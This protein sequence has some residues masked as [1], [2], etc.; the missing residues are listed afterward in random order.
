MWLKD[1]DQNTKYFHACA[2]Q[3]HKSNHLGCIIDINGRL[4]NTHET[5]SNAFVNYFSQLFRSM[6]VGNVSACL[7]A[8]DSKLT[9]EMNTALL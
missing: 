1:G 4:W 8:L 6:P 5:V 3:R 7:N 2:I 9:R